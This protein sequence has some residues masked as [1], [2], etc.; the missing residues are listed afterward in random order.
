MISARDLLGKWP[1]K[2]EQFNAT[3]S[4]PETLKKNCEFYKNNSSRALI[5]GEVEG[6]H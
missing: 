1:K 5:G 6:P 2:A 3:R 4:F